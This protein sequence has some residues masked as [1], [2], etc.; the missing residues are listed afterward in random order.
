MNCNYITIL[1]DRYPDSLKAINYPPF[2]IYYK[3]DLSLLDTRL[4][5]MVG[6][7]NPSEYGINEASHLSSF[8]ATN[9]VTTISGM[10][11]GI[12]TK[13]HSFIDEDILLMVYPLEKLSLRCTFLMENL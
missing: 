7:R 11:L 13:V 6:M 2:V 12:E 1:D 8:L 10:G 3:G 9:N 5:S 4:V